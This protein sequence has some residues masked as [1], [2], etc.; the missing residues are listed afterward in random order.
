MKTRERILF[1]SQDLFNRFGETN[2]GTV[3]ISAE[4]D[5]SPGNLYY[6]FSNKEAII[7]E[8]FNRLDDHMSQA[9]SATETSITHP[10]NAWLHLK[11][12]F[13]LIWNHRFVYRDTHH[14]I[15]KDQRL[16]KRFHLLL[17]KKSNTIFFIINAFIE[18]E[19][20]VVEADQKA[21]LIENLLIIACYSTSYVDICQTSLINH[22]NE[23]QR[24]G[25]SHPPNPRA[26]EK[27]S[28][29]SL[30]VEFAIQQM[31]MLIQPYVHPEFRLMFRD[32]LK[33]GLK[34]MH[35]Q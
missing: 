33:A 5:I 1:T 25:S 3:D 12:I 30:T 13:E 22:N 28:H 34:E 8:L 15:A 17:K 23:H 19:L 24:P 4:L 9:L 14:L 29:S 35:T 11:L 16:Q 2:I 20:L 7:F 10:I 32:S 6:H 31:A 26:G 21:P 27:P 18:R